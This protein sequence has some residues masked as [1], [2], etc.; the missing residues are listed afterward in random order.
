[1]EVRK[2]DSQT[3]LPNSKGETEGQRIRFRKIGR[4]GSEPLGTNSEPQ[5]NGHA[6]PGTRHS[7]QVRVP[8]YCLIGNSGRE[9]VPGP[10]DSTGVRRPKSRYVARIRPK[11]SSRQAEVRPVKRPIDRSRPRTHS[12]LTDR[13]EKTQPSQ[14]VTRAAYSPPRRTVHYGVD[15]TSAHIW[16]RVRRLTPSCKARNAVLQAG[17]L[18]SMTV[19]KVLLD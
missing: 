8:H 15:C 17:A 18:S 14:P 11:S 6:P 2:L 3:G 9:G 7:C 10:P 1:M 12:G 19:T 5:R 4:N 16:Y 13:P